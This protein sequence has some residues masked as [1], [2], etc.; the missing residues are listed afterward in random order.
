MRSDSR[1]VS[2]WQS[3]RS[4]EPNTLLRLGVSV[5]LA[6]LLAGLAMLLAVALTMG[7]GR[8]SVLDEAAAAMLLGALVL[9]LIALWRIWSP[10]QRV[11][12]I[13]RPVIGTVIV[14]AFTI[15]GLFAADHFIGY[16]EE[17]AMAG[18]GLCSAA[19]VLLLWLAALH[20][21]FKRRP[22]F[23]R[24]NQVDV[25]C[26]TCNY[27]LVGLRDL[28]C[29]EC[30][31]RFTIDELIRAQHY[32]SSHSRAAAITPSPPPPAEVTPRQSV[33]A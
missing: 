30:G 15:P 33:E 31:A 16:D 12:P 6:G 25:R 19:I 17:Y 13:T 14:T 8:S 29:P 2:L 27:S 23:D 4:S 32:S 1:Y 11:R 10:A 9:W 21:L 5:A 28:R 26:P 7:L 18:I 3:L 22:V 20:R 24:D